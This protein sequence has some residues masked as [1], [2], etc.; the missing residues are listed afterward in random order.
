MYFKIKDDINVAIVKI[1]VKV[2]NQTTQHRQR[3]A[4]RTEYRSKT[5]KFERRSEE[6]FLRVQTT[7]KLSVNHLLN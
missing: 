5:V 7:P 4:Q 1:R 6:V 3:H 2:K